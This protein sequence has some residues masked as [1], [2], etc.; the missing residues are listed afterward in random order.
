MHKTTFENYIAEH[1]NKFFIEIGINI[2]NKISPTKNYYTDYLL[3]PNKERFLIAPATDEEI[4]D[5]TS[6]LNIR[7]S[8][9]PNSILTKVMKQIKDVISAPSAKLT[10]RSFHNGV[11]PNILKI[12]KIIPI[13]KSESRVACNNNGNLKVKFND[14]KNMNFDSLESLGN[15]IESKLGIGELGNRSIEKMYHQYD[16]DTDNIE[17]LMKEEINEIRSTISSG[18]SSLLIFFA[19]KFSFFW[20]QPSRG[21]LGRGCSGGMQRI[22][23]GAPVPE[24]DFNEVAK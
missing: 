7:K 24:C 23:G 22:C 5:I 3:N 9:G 14:N 8:T 21:V 13:F 19:F 16:T 12:A 6:D 20:K 1:F 18:N 15:V 11:F 2:Q 10:N 17:T 4:S